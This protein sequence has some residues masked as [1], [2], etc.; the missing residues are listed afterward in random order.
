MAALR[1][2]PALRTLF[3]RIPALRNRLRRPGW[4]ALLLCGAAL[5]AG[6]LTWAHQAETGPGL[7]Q[8]SIEYISV[9]RSLLAGEGFTRFFGGTL[10]GR[11]PLYP[12]L[13][14]GG[15]LGIFD[16]Y[17]VAG[18]L[19]VATSAL[20]VIFVG[21]WLRRRL[22]SDL[23]LAGGCL[24]VALAAPL[25][26]MAYWALSETAFI[27][28]AMLSLICL[29]GYLDSRRRSLLAGA[30]TLAAL[31]CLTRYLGVAVIAAGVLLLLLQRGASPADRVKETAVYVFIAAAPAALWILRTYLI[32]GTSIGAR[33]DIYYSAA[34]IWNELVG[35]L[36][37]IDFLLTLGGSASA[38]WIAGGLIT[39][40][41]MLAAA[42][43]VVGALI[44]AQQIKTGWAGR[45]SFVVFVGFAL[46]YAVVLV[47]A[48]MSGTTSSWG[49]PR[50]LIPLYLPLLIA[51]LL[52]MDRAL[53]YA[54]SRAV[55]NAGDGTG[56]PHRAVAAEYWRRGGVPLAAALLLT[57]AIAGQAVMTARSIALANRDY[58]QG[59]Q[60]TR[61]TD[62]ATL[63]YI[64]EQSLTGVL[65]SEPAAAAYFHT[66]IDAG[67][68]YLPC[69]IAELRQRLSAAN[70]SDS[71]SDV[72]IVWFPDWG[73]P[74][75]DAGVGGYDGDWLKAR[76]WLETVHEAA[77]GIILRF[78]PN[79][80]N[81]NG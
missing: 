51:A 61:W 68:R 1:R 52:V 54:R 44:R 45:R 9:A 23:L 32:T 71:G 66:D 21:R 35:M 73:N 22:E 2:I 14:A 29:D 3:L 41:L 75:C 70:D 7:Q 58:Y 62:S 25:L 13:L 30:A 69:G 56:V 40:G 33:D 39:G 57:L 59:Y 67:H 37:H 55:A 80:S 28:L 48:L 4:F 53:S 26:W 27:L 10:K 20:I 11:P 81:G 18:P 64:R 34:D 36:E 60:H 76:P 8:D 72:Y 49:D 24:A 47:I 15:S 31:T 79:Y 65:F 78:N 50:Y 17:K 5:L 43:V 38:A 42:A 46:S 63:R 12:L 19:N 16:P 77:D 74:K 6:G